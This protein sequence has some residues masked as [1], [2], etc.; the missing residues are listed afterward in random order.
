MLLELKNGEPYSIT[1]DGF[2]RSSPLLGID[3][4]PAVLPPILGV[5][6]NAG[7]AAGRGC[8]LWEREVAGAPDMGLE[9]HLP[10]R[11]KP[12]PK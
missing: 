7:G 10:Q 6:L 2:M 11:R 1:G 5:W 8:P 9:M 4:R 3:G 12:S